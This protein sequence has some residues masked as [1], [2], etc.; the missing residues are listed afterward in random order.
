[1][2]TVFEDDEE[3]ERAEPD[4]ELTLSAGTLL[5]LFFALVLVCGLCFGV[6]YT[7]GEHSGG[8]MTAKGSEKVA[9]TAP[10]KMAGKSA[11][12]PSPAADSTGLGASVVGTGNNFAAGATPAA[13]MADVLS[14]APET[15]GSAGSNAA[16]LNGA[17]QQVASQSA[18]SQ[19]QAIANGAAGVHAALPGGMQGTTQAN[20]A[21]GNGAAA[22]V[23]PAMPESGPKS[24]IVLGAPSPAA[25]SSMVQV[26]AVSDPVDAQ[27]LLD[28]LRKRGYPVKLI[29]GTTDSLTRV[30]VGP[31]ASRA[32]ALATR[33]KLLHDGYNAIV[34]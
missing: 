24:G 10:D 26:A 13:P 32:Q 2:R 8:A 25:E 29:R 11:E 20:S 5:G 12:K 34:K 3:D 16:G 21:T 28:A 4:R 22:V 33:A 19:A 9:P 17:G 30:Q 1:L 15:P 23:R 31:F 6:G 7:L 27:V 14:P 18:V